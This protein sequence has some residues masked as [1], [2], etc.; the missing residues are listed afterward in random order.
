MGVGWWQNQRLM[1]TFIFYVSG[2][3][4]AYLCKI[5]QESPSHS[6]RAWESI[7]IFSAKDRLWVGVERNMR[8]EIRENIGHFGVLKFSL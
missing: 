3:E 5:V 2:Y 8:W 1:G 6:Q 7:R 4:S